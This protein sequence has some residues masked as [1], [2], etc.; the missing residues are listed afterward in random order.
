MTMDPTIA[1]EAEGL[2]KRYR[3]GKVALQGI[4][5]RV[6][7]GA[8]FGLLGP[9]GAGKSTAIAVLTTLLLPS[10]GTARIG[11][12]DVVHQQDTVRRTIGVAL[13]DTGVD[14]LLSGWEA[15]TL[16]ARLYGADGGE[17]RARTRALVERFQLADFAER[18]IATYSGGMRRRLDLALALAHAPRVLFLDE[19]TTG[20]DPESRAAL[21][22]LIGQTATELGCTVF[23]TTQYL[24]EADS[25]CDRVAILRDGLLVAE[26]TPA[27]LKRRLQRDVVELEARD[28]ADTDR[29]LAAVRAVHPR[30]DREGNTVRVVVPSGAAEVPRLLAAVSEAGIT[31][32]GLRVQPP[33]LD[34]VFVALVHETADLP[35]ANT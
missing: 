4:D 7:A 2:Q 31:L 16:Q 22:T 34:D 21:W 8:I 14:P 23:L 33:S 24:E 10:G 28:P 5:L 12:Q 17:A 26:D 32:S 3:D 18:R 29:L 6:P 1:I 35:T 20:L 25:L 30:P 9:N 19:P 15:L 27:Q 11:G 13:Q